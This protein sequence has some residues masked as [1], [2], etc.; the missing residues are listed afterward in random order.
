MLDAVVAAA[1]QNM[2][3]T[4]DVAVHVSER[5][6]DRVAHTRL[7]GEVDDAFGFVRGERIGN[8]FWVGQIGAYVG[9][10]R[11]IHKP[12]EARFFDG[13]VIVIIVVIEPDDAITPRE[14]TL[15]QRRSDEPGRTG[16][17]GS[18]HGSLS[19]VDHRAR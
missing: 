17:E 16:D 10:I 15:G 7:R 2:R 6:L 4:N 14:Q 11:M 19:C 12:R 9:V 18:G 13:W 8:G 3:E 1:F 5:I